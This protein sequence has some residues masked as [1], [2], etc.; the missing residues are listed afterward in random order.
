MMRWKLMIFT[1]VVVVSAFSALTV[2]AGPY[3]D[4]VLADN[5]SGYWRL[6]ESGGTAVDSAT[7]IGGANDGTFVGA[8]STTTGAI[9]S[10]TSNIA[11]Q[12]TGQNDYVQ[13]LDTFTNGAM[14]A[15][16]F[17][18]EQWLKP[19]NSLA[20][21][22]GN[23]VVRGFFFGPG[24]STCCHSQGT[25][26]FGNDTLA[27][28]DGLTGSNIITTPSGTGLDPFNWTHVVFT[29]KSDGAGGTDM[30]LYFNGEQKAAGNTPGNVPDDNAGE[31]I[32]IG[33]LALGPEENPYSSL[34][35]GFK[36]G[37]DEVAYYNYA[38][39]GSSICQH[40]Q[41][42][43][44]SCTDPGPPG[45]WNVDATS[46][47]QSG[48]N[49][50]LNDSPN[51][52]NDIAQF[53]GATTGPRTVFTESP[54]T[55]N[56]IVFDN[57][58]EYVV[59]GNHPVSLSAST[60][61]VVVDPSITVSSGSHKFTTEVN[62]LNDT[63]LSIDS[64]AS[65]EFINQLSLNGNVLT[66]TGDGVLLINSDSNTGTGTIDV[67]GGVLA[68]GG[69][70]SGNVIIGAGA[71]LS[72]GS[73]S[74]PPLAVAT[75]VPEPHS[76]ILIA[77]GLLTLGWSTRR[78]QVGRK[79]LLL[80]LLLVGIGTL[81]VEGQGYAQSL[82]DYRN[83]VLAD[84]PSGYWPLDETSGTTA[85]DISAVGGNNDG[86]YFAH[87]TRPGF[88]TGSDAFDSTGGINDGSASN[89]Y[90]RI[91]DSGA[92]AFT[93]GAMAATSFSV[94][95]WVYADR[96]SGSSPP[97]NWFVRGFFFG[98]GGQFIQHNGTSV[99]VGVDNAGGGLATIDSQK[100]THVVATFADDG[101]GD[102]DL[103]VYVDGEQFGPFYRSELPLG[104]IPNFPA[105]AGDNTGED[106]QIGTLHFFDYDQRIQG[107]DGGID[108]LAY[109]DYALDATR[110]RAHCEAGSSTCAPTVPHV[111]SENGSGS[112]QD[113][114]NWSFDDSPDNAEEIAQLTGFIDSP[115]TV[116]TESPIT[117]NGIVFDNAN[118]YVVAG[119]DAI[120]LSQTGGGTDPTIDVM[121]GD[122]QIQTE[123]LLTDDLTINVDAGATLEFVNRLTLDGNVLTKTGSGTLIINESFGDVP[124]VVV[125]ASAAT[126]P[127]PN[128]GILLLG[129]LS[130]GSWCRWRKRM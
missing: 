49:W 59:G 23:S 47:W 93:N 91:S 53:T 33:T 60:I 103:T 68:A 125:A 31:D 74:P 36:G 19:D 71:T 1:F 101:A 58:N 79:K 37:I 119:N 73:N 84:N 83:A 104:G 108:E 52:V 89:N 54:V 18:I 39:S 67:Q 128:S 2:Y 120:T 63:A 87:A 111:W 102:T 116:F 122:H 105:V 96:L 95:A 17:T 64:N 9:P 70:I 50:T 21:T 80:T 30:A 126:I 14:S 129:C 13:I 86:T 22:Q 77:A 51:G 56:G 85:A 26:H 27:G 44:G 98:A 69:N 82:T 94:E 43:G 3:V 99:A 76:A 61:P 5:P 78:S 11:F 6:E 88:I 32:Q 15:T 92:T 109:Y 75:Q 10:E 107:F 106:I 34:V 114:S 97:G 123:V 46:S 8:I 57:A 117:I 66:K 28:I 20:I 113:D 90:V 38:L 25:L 12:S 7:T 130:A 115:R 62:L 112:W 4:A 42:A 110:V 35:Q 127:E 40:Y 118:Q 29:A 24:S 45:I 41:A 121:S 55:V 72:A 81:A 65:L 100:W 48:P 124:V 16:E